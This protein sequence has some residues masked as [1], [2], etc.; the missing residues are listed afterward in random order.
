VI[1]LG[2][3][4]A[5]G[6]LLQVLVRVLGRQMASASKP[7]VRVTAASHLVR[8]GVLPH[9]HVGGAH[10]AAGGEL[11]TVLGGRDHN[12]SQTGRGEFAGF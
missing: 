3:G 10:V 8:G 7:A 2:V 9:R 5:D 12:C 6:L 1:E 11:H 4:A